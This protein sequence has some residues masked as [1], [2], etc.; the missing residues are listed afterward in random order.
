ME[1]FYY[2]DWSGVAVKAVHGAAGQVHRFYNEAPQEAVARLDES[3]A[4]QD[5]QGDGE[6][7]FLGHQLRAKGVLYDPEE[8]ALRQA[9]QDSGGAG[10]PRRRDEGC[11]PCE[12]ARNQGLDAQAVGAGVRGNGRERLPGNGSPKVNKDYEI[13]KLRKRIE[14][15]E[16]ENEL[17]KNFRAFL[18]QDH[19]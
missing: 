16:R 14:E 2:R 15:L 10:G 9:V 13:V 3:Y 11:R 8:E 1:F 4:V 5:K 12:G 18:S 7:K 6:G 19:A 17:L